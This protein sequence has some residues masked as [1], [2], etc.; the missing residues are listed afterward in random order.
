MALWLC[1]FIQDKAFGVLALVAVGFVFGHYM[2]RKK[3]YQHQWEEYQN[4]P[5][6]EGV[7]MVEKIKK[8]P[9][10]FQI[11]F[12]LKQGYVLY[13]S[14]NQLNIGDVY[15]IQGKIISVDQAHYPG[16]FNYRAYLSYQNIYGQI[17]IKEMVYVQHTFGKYQL[18]QSISDYYEQYFHTES[19]GMIQ[20]LTIGNKDRLNP[21]LSEQIATIGVSHLFVISGLHVGLLVGALEKLLSLLRIKKNA[22]P[23]FVMPLLFLYY[24]ISGFIVSV[25]RVVNGFILK[26]LNH[27]YQLKWS[28]I[29]LISINAYLVLCFNPMYIF[30]YNFILSYLIAIGIVLCASWLFNRKGIVGNIKTNIIISCIATFITLPVV[31]IFSPDISFLAIV[32]NLVYIPLVSYILLPLAVL[33]T[34]IPCLENLFMI[35]YS[36]F[37]LLTNH[38]AQ[39]DILTFTYPL[40]PP[41]MILF[42]YFLCYGLI[43]R[44]KNIRKYVSCL[45]ILFQLIWIYWGY[46]NVHERVYFLD[47]PRGEATFIQ[48]KHNQLNILID[49]GESGSND[50]IVF[51]KKQGVKRIDAIII[52]HGDS[53]HN[54][55]LLELIQTFR[56]K[57]VYGSKYDITTYQ[58]VKDKVHYQALSVGD[59]LMYQ[60]N[61]FQVLSPIK[62]YQKKNNNSLVILAQLFEQN[63]LFT[64]DI[65]KEVEKQLPK[66]EKV[67][68]L[69]VPHHGSITSS[70]DELLHNVQYA[71]A[72]CM[73]GYQ[74]QF[75]FPS[76]KIVERYNGRIW[77]TS[78]KGTIIIEK[79]RK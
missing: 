18:Y 34:C 39:I 8:T 52:S 19:V 40:I 1:Y 58:M 14:E 5:I 35:V 12:H 68:Y 54:G 17:E 48:G 41:F 71:I 77:I 57:Q 3:C 22:I 60:D 49:T 10:H 36:L 11:L 9:Q 70:T 50:L 21:H 26:T 7:A 66:I 30:Q 6:Y 25:L 43:S 23:V 69:K 78:E 53:D 73:N 55:M 38:L 42:Y 13:Y 4:F 28:A 45:F 74:N 2:F 47:L 63:Y 20:A 44:K 37:Q 75:S 51:L 15:Y 59:T 27:Q 79:K 32:Y 65:E 31:T 62:D 61:C 29:D 33:V 72:I 16:G 67:D 76:P 64:G 56:V 46:V 24:A